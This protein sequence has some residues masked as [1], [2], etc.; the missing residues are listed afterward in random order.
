VFLLSLRCCAWL[1]SVRSHRCGEMLSG[2]LFSRSTEEGLLQPRARRAVAVDSILAIMLVVMLDRE[3][4]SAHLELSP[5]V[6][7]S[8]LEK[9]DSCEIHPSH[10]HFHMQVTACL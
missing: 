5:A 10:L 3:C 9:S 1:Q 7:S 6:R 2:R 4:T 8:K